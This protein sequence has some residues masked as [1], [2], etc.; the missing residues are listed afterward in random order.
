MAIQ[1]DKRENEIIALLRLQKGTTRS[2]VDAFYRFEENGQ[3]YSA[4]IELKSTTNETVSTARD[5]G[6]DHIQKWR[7]RI[8]IIGYYNA[9]GDTLLSLLALSSQDMDS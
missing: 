2:G 1:D 3:E 7:R 5:V 8:W 6:M 4:E 9:S